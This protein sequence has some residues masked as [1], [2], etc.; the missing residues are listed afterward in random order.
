[1]GRWFFVELFDGKGLCTSHGQHG[2]RP[3]VHHGIFSL[4]QLPQKTERPLSPASSSFQEAARHATPK[5]PLSACPSPST[6]K[7]AWEL[8]YQFCA[9]LAHLRGCRREQH[10]LSLITQSR[11]VGAQHER[12]A[13]N[14][15]TSVGSSSP[16]KSALQAVFPILNGEGSFTEEELYAVLDPIHLWWS[17]EQHAACFALVDTA[18]AC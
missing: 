16:R 6:R 8:H 13:A 1:M 12:M 5:P 14:G 7:L 10:Q 4:Y 15:A 18:G 3:W 11:F 9:F 17:E 2:D